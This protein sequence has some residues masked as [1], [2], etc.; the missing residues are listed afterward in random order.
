MGKTVPMS[1]RKPPETDVANKEAFVRAANE[2]S[3]TA[4]TVTS[5]SANSVKPKGAIKRS[6]G[7][8]ARRLVTYLAPELMQRLRMYCAAQEKSLT[9]AVSEAV[10]GYLDVKTS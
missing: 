6:D 5:P 4:K 8:E 1:L 3:Q 10:E 2:P 9:E 7:S